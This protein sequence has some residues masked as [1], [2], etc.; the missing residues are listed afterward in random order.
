MKKLKLDLD[1]LNVFSFDTGT[2]A[3]RGG[4]VI[5][6]RPP[7]PSYITCDEACLQTRDNGYTCQYTCGQSCAETCVLT[8]LTNECGGCQ[9]D[10]I[11]ICV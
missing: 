3:V 10:T 6:H 2:A 1:E 4:T 7:P 11:N 8:R 5:A 9:P